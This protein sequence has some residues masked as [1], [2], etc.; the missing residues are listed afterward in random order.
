MET[1][2]LNR[3]NISNLAERRD[4]FSISLSDWS[5]NNKSSIMMRFS[6]PIFIRPMVSC[7]PRTLANSFATSTDICR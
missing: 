3:G 6:S 4:I 1:F 7:V 5:F 2:P